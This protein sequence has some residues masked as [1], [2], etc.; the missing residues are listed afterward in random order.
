[1]SDSVLFIGSGN[2]GSAIIKGCVNSK[3]LDPSDISVYDKDPVKTSKLGIENLNILT[4]LSLV[5]TYSA[6][7]IAVKPKDMDSVLTE[8]SKSKTNQGIIISIVAG[9]TIRHISQILGT[10]KPIARVMPNMN[11]LISAGMNVIAYNKSVDEKKRELTKAIFK[12]VGEIL[13]TDESKMNA[14]TGLSGSG[15]AFVFMFIQALADGGVKVGLSRDEALLLATETVLGSAKTV[16]Y[17]GIHPE[18]L[19]DMVASPGGTTIEGIHI[20]EQ[21]KFRGLIMEAVEV[22]KNKADVLGEK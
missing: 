6:I 22:A 11:A 13:E 14:V 5:E 4:E 9:I 3:L 16:K 20:L 15:P 10:E 17:S 1:M 7:L 8:L 19:K 2:M 21:N 18:K 12:S